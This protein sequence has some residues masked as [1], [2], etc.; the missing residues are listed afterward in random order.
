MR[1]REWKIQYEGLSDLCFS[2]GKNGHQEA[3]CLVK[4]MNEPLE[5]VSSSLNNGEAQEMPL[6]RRG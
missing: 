4:K 5:G 2:C 1:E 6:E 3:V